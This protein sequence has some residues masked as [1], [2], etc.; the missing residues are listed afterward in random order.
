MGL[1]MYLYRYTFVS[2]HWGGTVGSINWEGEPDKEQQAIDPKRIKYIVEEVAYWRK[3]NAIHRWF[4]TF[5]QEG[6]DECLTAYVAREQLQELLALTEE[7]LHHRDPEVAA[8]LLPT[9]GGF[10]FGSTD[11]DEWYWKD[12]EYTRDTLKQIL[13]EPSEDFRYH[14]SW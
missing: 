10:F 8:E 2:E 13:E 4:I 6:E 3:A 14:S 5:V 9:Q 11:Y 12:L 7:V 1:D